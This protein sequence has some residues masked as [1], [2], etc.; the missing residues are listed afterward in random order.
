MN[1]DANTTLR[2][3]TLNQSYTLQH[4]DYLI[5]CGLTKLERESI[6]ELRADVFCDELGWVPPQANATEFD[7]FDK[8]VIDISVYTDTTSIA[9]LRLHPYWGGWMINTVFK[10]LLP[11]DMENLKTP[12]TCEVS[13]L[14]VRKEFRRHRFADNSEPVDALYRGLFS[15]C[16]LNHIRYVYMIVSKQVFRVLRHRGLPCQRIGA[17]KIMDDGVIALAARLDW[18]EFMQTNQQLNPQRFTRFFDALQRASFAIDSQNK[19]SGEISLTADH[20]QEHAH[21]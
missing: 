20:T 2:P 14:A 6:Y 7:E 5:K 9:C 12:E 21:G 16:L 8:T 13:R 10:S 15:F 18:V 19:T 1:T 4:D 11:A 3:S 17:P